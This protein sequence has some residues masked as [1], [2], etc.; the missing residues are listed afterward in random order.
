MHVIGVAEPD[1]SSNEA[2]ILA[3]RRY[4]LYE[5]EIGDRMGRMGDALTVVGVWGFWGLR[6]RVMVRGLN[7]DTGYSALTWGL[8][9]GLQI[10]L[11]KALLADDAD[12]PRRGPTAFHGAL[13]RRSTYTGG[14]EGAGILQVCPPRRTHPSQTTLDSV[15]VKHKSPNG[16]SHTC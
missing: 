14:L 3:A 2:E 1:P 6:R 9:L 7:T 15:S 13:R 10:V 4:M 5:Q 8:C 16:P 12:L 11:D